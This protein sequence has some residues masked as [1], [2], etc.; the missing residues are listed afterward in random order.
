MVNA[1]MINNPGAA[2][3]PGAAAILGGKL[4]CDICGTSA[5]YLGGQLANYTEAGVQN[6]ER[7]FENAAKQIQTRNKIEG[8][9]PPRVLK[10]ILSEGYF[11]EDEVQA[12]YLG[13]VLASSKGPVSRDDRAIAYCS[14]LSSLSTY[15]IRTHCILYSTILRATHFCVGGQPS[16]IKIILPTIQKQSLT[17]L[18]READYRTAMDLSESEQPENIAQHS[19][20]G[21]E[22]RGLSERGI[23]LCHPRNPKDGE[24]PFRCFYPTILGA[25]LFLWGNGFGDCG[26]EAYKPDLLQKIKLPFTVE[27]YEV[28]PG[29]VGFA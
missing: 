1:I 2:V 16:P 15:Q 28:H 19:F 11:C 24:V 14:L 7:I 13:G 3:V 6:L 20:V 10:K 12:M 27:P 4:L 18:I 25:E 5:K 29:Q 17:I 9:V 23:Y 21:L 22:K 26:V 8:Q